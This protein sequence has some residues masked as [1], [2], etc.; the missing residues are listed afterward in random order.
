MEV[1]ELNED[2]KRWILE[3]AMSTLQIDQTLRKVNFTRRQF[4]RYLKANPAFKAE[5]EQALLDSCAF[6]ENDLL[7]IHKV[8]DDAK[9]ASIRITAIQKALAYRQPEKYGN[10]IDLSLNQTVSIKSNVEKA[11]ERLT[12]TLRDVVPLTLIDG[13]KE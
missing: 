1:R 2:E 12:Q 13:V 7:N 6:L 10:K 9:M 4:S 8:E 3:D 5:Y 11:N